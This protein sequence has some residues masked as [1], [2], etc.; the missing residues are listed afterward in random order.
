MFKGPQ[1]PP[2]E[3]GP[4]G[5]QG[6][7]GPQ[8]PNGLSIQGAPVSFHGP[9]FLLTSW[10]VTQSLFHLYFNFAFFLFQF[11]SL[12]GAPGE[13]GEKGEIGLPGPQVRKKYIARMSHQHSRQLYNTHTVSR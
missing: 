3:I 11:L 6:P 8:G 12:Q 7:P 2:G 1:G 5:P 4:S 13:K 9:S 10:I